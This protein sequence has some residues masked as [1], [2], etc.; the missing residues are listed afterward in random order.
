MEWGY[1]DDSIRFYMADSKRVGQF[2]RPNKHDASDAPQLISL[3]EHVHT[4]QLSTA[5]FVDANTLVTAGTDCTISVWAVPHAGK[6][7]ELQPKACLFGHRA[8][9]DV[10]AVSKSF[11]T[12]LSADSNGEVLMWDLNRLKIVRVL[13]SGKPVEVSYYK[14][15]LKSKAD[16]RQCARINDVSG[17]VMLCRG[18]TV[19]LFTLNGD[20]VL[21]QDVCHESDDT[22]TACAFYQGAGNEFL[23][24][25]L[26][27]TGHK[28]GVVNVR[29]QHL[30]LLLI[31]LLIGAAGLE[32][33]Q[34]KR[35]IRA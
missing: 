20:P 2:N 10:L 11:S 17:T 1:I 14:Q 32:S 35:N 25:N 30:Q 24:R 16:P 18:R 27:F 31:Y 15:I 9:I 12:L 22:I 4:G 3:S 34:Q 13:T 5:L 28:R 26:V 23:E 19:S 21:T 7:V 6:S 29:P 8:A 33:Y